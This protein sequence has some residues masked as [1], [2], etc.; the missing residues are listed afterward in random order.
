MLFLSTDVG[1]TLFLIDVFAPVFRLDVLKEVPVS[2]II[3]R[4]IS[5]DYI[6]ISSVFWMNWLELAT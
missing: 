4:M 1:A 6:S 3:H 5:C 2:Y